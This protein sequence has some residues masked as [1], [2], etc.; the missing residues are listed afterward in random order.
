[1]LLDDVLKF[2]DYEHEHKGSHIALVRRFR[3]DLPLVDIDENSIKQVLINILNNSYESMPS[4][5]VITV[6]SQFDKDKDVVIIEVSDLGCGI[7]EESLEEIF[8]PFFTLKDTGVGLGLAICDQI[9]KAHNGEIILMN[10][11]PR[12]VKCIIKLPVKQ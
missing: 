10:N 2:L 9:V 7:P 3:L 8:V 4:G 12:G 5:G 6:V 1:M 11:S